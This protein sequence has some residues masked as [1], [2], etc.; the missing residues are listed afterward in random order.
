MSSQY[1]SPGQSHFQQKCNLQKNIHSGK[2]QIYL[3]K[4]RFTH[5]IK[6][7]SYQ[8]SKKFLIKIL[9]QFTG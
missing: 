1:L 5:E 6:N 4:K 8:W 7:L 3:K 9:F 2:I